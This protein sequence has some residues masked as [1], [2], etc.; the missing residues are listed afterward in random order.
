[1]GESGQEG[2]IGQ[3]RGGRSLY[4]GLGRE[5][6]GEK[7]IQEEWK[8]LKERVRGAIGTTGAG[9][10][11]D[12]KK[13][14]WWDKECREEKSRVRKELRRWRREGGEGK[15]YR[16]R[17]KEYKVMCEG[18]KRK[19]VEK[20]EKEVEGVKTEGQVWKVVNRGRKRRGRVEEGI[21][22]EEWEDYFRGVLG[23]VEWRVRKGG[24]RKRGEDGE[25]ELSKE[26]IRRVVRGLKEGKAGGGD[27]IPNEVWK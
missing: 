23:G 22:M 3:Q 25:E 15:E 8:E 5:R 2:E 27:G 19:E 24:E 7:G 16:E 9:G 6:G 17:K 20:W 11:K 10:K 13:G 21:R 14:G 1:M 26:E 18:K 4:E 12:G